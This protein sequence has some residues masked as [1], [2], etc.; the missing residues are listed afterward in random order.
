MIDAKELRILRIEE[1]LERYSPSASFL[2]TLLASSAFYNPIASLKWRIKHFSYSVKVTKT[3]KLSSQLKALKEESLELSLKKSNQK[4]MFSPALP[5]AHQSFCVFQLVPKVQC[6]GGIEYG[7]LPTITIMDSG[8]S[9][10]IAKIQDRRKRMKAK[11][12]NGNGFGVSLGEKIQM[13]PTVQSRD[14]RSPDKPESWNY[15]RKVKEGYTIDL[16]SVIGMIPTPRQNMYKGGS[17]NRAGKSNRLDDL[18][19]AKPGLKLQPGFAAWMMNLPED[20]TLKPF[21]NQNGEQKV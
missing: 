12:Y 8:I 20:W 5:M 18:V 3:K 7:L 21:Q 15:K 6:I 1:L 11:G 2:K 10:E 19:E 17:K 9:T 14:Y 16:N 13:L 4:D